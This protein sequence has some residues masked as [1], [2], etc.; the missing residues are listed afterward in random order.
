MSHDALVPLLTMALG[1]IV[2][3]SLVGWV[4]SR[5]RPAWA[6]S[7]LLAQV[8]VAAFFLAV[9]LTPQAQAD[10]AVPGSPKLFSL[11]L[12]LGLLGLFKLLG[13]FEEPGS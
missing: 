7:T 11:V 9:V 5:T 6:R 8:I 1:L 2:I 3:L 13:R 4:L 10:S 12:F